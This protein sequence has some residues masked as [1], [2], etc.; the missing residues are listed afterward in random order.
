MVTLSLF[1]L[2]VAL[3]VC[4]FLYLY[5]ALIK[6]NPVEEQLNQI[7]SYSLEENWEEAQSQM[8]Q[9]K[10][11]WERV[12]YPL[13]INYADVD[14]TLFSQLL[15]QIESSIKTKE[16]SQAASDASAAL[17]I[18]NNIINVVPQP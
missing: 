2:M 6:V 1:G 4:Y 13:A 3:Y 10:K 8:T 9:L 16:L 15:E 7:I 5:L 17:R 11:S 12:K 14:Y 18:W